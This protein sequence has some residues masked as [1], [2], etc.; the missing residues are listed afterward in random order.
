[1]IEQVRLWLVIVECGNERVGCWVTS[2]KTDL[3]APLYFFSKEYGQVVLDGFWVRLGLTEEERTAALE[4]LKCSNLPEKLRT[5]DG[6]AG[7]ANRSFK[8]I[9]DALTSAL[10]YST[11]DPEYFFLEVPVSQN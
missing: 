6:S 8:D 4:T 5:L 2:I 11:E 1:M 10:V 7:R 3:A 9:A